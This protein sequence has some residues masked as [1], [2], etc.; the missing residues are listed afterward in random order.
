MIFRFCKTPA[1]RSAAAVDF[2]LDQ[3]QNVVFPTGTNQVWQA[4]IVNGN[5]FNITKTCDLSS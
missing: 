2:Y 5:S 3:N 4:K 1:R